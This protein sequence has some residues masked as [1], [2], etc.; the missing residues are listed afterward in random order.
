MYWNYRLWYEEV[1]SNSKNIPNHKKYGLY[2]TYY[3][4]KGEIIART[5]HPLSLEH[6]VFFDE[7]TNKHEQTEE[8]VVESFKQDITYML[9]ALKAP[10]VNLDTIVFGDVEDKDEEELEIYS[11]KEES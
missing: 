1:D 10:A 4:D 3:N 7:E 6:F 2:E 5:E 8:E 11:R 9:Q